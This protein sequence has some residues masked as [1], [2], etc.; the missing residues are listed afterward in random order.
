M[1]RAGKIY[2][3]L[4]SFTVTLT[5]TLPP[6]F[7]GYV[8]C[9]DDQQCKRV[10]YVRAPTNSAP[11]CCNTLAL[12]A[13]IETPSAFSDPTKAAESQ[14]GLFKDGYAEMKACLEEMKEMKEAGAYRPT[15]P[16]LSSCRPSDGAPSTEAGRRQSRDT[17]TEPPKAHHRS[18]RQSSEPAVASYE[19]GVRQPAAEGRAGAARGRR[20]VDK[21]GVGG[22]RE[23]A[24]E[25]RGG[26][27]SSRRPVADESD[28]ARD[29]GDDGS[30]SSS[31]S[32]AASEGSGTQWVRVTPTDENSSEEEDL[33]SPRSRSPDS[34][35][36]ATATPWLGREEL[37]RRYL[38]NI[39]SGGDGAEPE[40]APSGS[41]SR[42]RRAAEARPGRTTRTTRASAPVPSA[43]G[44]GAA[45]GSP[46]GSRRS[47]SPDN[48]SSGSSSSS[49][50]GG[51]GGGDGERAPDEYG[52]GGRLHDESDNRRHGIKKRQDKLRGVLGTDLAAAETQPPTTSPGGVIDRSSAAAAAAAGAVRPRLLDHGGDEGSEGTLPLSL[53]RAKSGE[54]GGDGGKAA[55]A[56][57]GKAWAGRGLSLS[58]AAA[59][60]K[61]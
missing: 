21:S 9:Y 33:G 2:P 10:A 12:S 51:D 44:N 8:S 5:S 19:T 61:G 34:R 4:V 50:G 26:R 13:P 40:T 16:P 38:A 24:A 57:R 35:G 29:G 46:G 3:R 7:V 41:R 22:T 31:N 27:G 11:C 17:L 18:H 25:A 55:K 53:S 23:P 6:P 54:G 36:A 14:A 37:L 58:I 15:A 59:R 60:K 49:I 1:A 56:E 48:S 28:Y 45:G 52:P 39:G 32:S 20:Q 30:S 43:R 47:P 42:S